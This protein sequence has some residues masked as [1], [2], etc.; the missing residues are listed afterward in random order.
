M[1][2]KWNGFVAECSILVC[3]PRYCLTQPQI[4]IS[5]HIK[6]I[7]GLPP[8]MQLE[9]YRFHQEMEGFFFVINFACSTFSRRRRA[10][11]TLRLRTCVFDLNFNGEIQSVFTPFIH[12]LCKL[13]SIMYF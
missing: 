5:R 13:L 3:V 10:P 12:L 11:S 2:Q 9:C 6:R 8:H 4:V 7:L 1:D